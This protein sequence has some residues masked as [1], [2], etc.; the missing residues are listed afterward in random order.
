MP[1]CKLFDN[2]TWTRKLPEPFNASSISTKR[3]DIYSKYNNTASKSSTLQAQTLSGILAYME[4][5]S[6][7]TSGMATIGAI[8]TQG[9]DIIVAEYPSRRAGEIHT[10]VYNKLTG[11]FSVGIYT[12]SAVTPQSYTVK[13]DKDSGSAMFF[14]LMPEALTDT[15]FASEYARLL[16]CKNDGYADLSKASDAANILCDNLY[17]RVDNAANLGD[18]GIKLSIPNTGN[19]PP[20]SPLNLNKGVYS[21]DTVLFGEFKTVSPG[22]AP[23]ASV[24]LVKHEDFVGK[25]S[26]SERKLSVTDSRLI[27]KLE[28]WYIIPPEVVRICQ[29][30]KMTTGSKQ[31][32]RNFMMRGEAGTGKTEGAK[33]IAAGFGLPYVHI[34]C[35]AN[36]EIMDFLGQ[37]LPEMGNDVSK[38]SVDMQLPSFED[39]CMDPATAYCLMTGEYDESIT[40]GEVYDKLVETIAQTLK[41]PASAADS[42]KPSFR[43]VDTPLV[44]AIRYGYCC[45]IQ[46]P[47]IIAN[48]GVLVGLNS[49]LDRCNAITLPTGECIER[50]PDT[51]IIVTTN[52][53]Y[54]GCKDLNQSIISR[55]NLVIDMDTPDTETLI[56]RVAGITA[57]TELSKIK[58]MAESVKE[59]AE[60]CR[61]TMIT[62]GSCGVRELIAWV[63]SFMICGDILEAAKYTVL[64]SVSSDP[65]NRAEILTSCL[66]TRYAS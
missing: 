21:P 4:L 61:E 25:H 66:E 26:L 17:R 64:S 33:A 43:Y 3:T 49:L 29:H 7:S 48:P 23:E 13:E 39:I 65:E 19:M 44:N 50:H 22:S 18:A 47:S 8:G 1:K 27:P 28:D 24:A 51:V 15:E 11:K 57:C 59:I 9:A 10:V 53:N 58:S 62:D 16:D 14:A 34:T 45:E 5:E 38:S 63:Q 46:E 40:E 6:A 41:E 30:A 36:S 35:S 12:A 60:R 55:M 2:W 52:N 20:L 56:R 31:P 42:P 32:M 37:I 54:N